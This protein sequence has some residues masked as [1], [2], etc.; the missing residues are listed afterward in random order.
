FQDDGIHLLAPGIEAMATLLHQALE[1]LGIL[2][3]PPPP[4]IRILTAKLPDAH[5]GKPYAARLSAE[6]GRPPY[7]WSRVSA[8]PGGLTLSPTGQFSGTPT[9][10][11]GV[12]AVR[13]R[14]LDRSRTSTSR[15]VTLRVRP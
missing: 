5:D 2:A 4:P 7:R 3:A 13:V 6:G 12:F 11:P 9:A 8:L 14:V 10:R 1:S 15:R